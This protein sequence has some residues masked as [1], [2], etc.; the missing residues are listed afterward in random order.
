M[1][2]NYVMAVKTARMTATRDAMANGTLE[3][4]SAAGAALVVFGLNASGGTV[5]NDIWNLV[6]DSTT[7]AAVAGTNTVAT[8]AVLK[9]AGGTV[10]VSGLTV[11]VATGDPET[12]PDITLDAT[13]ITAGQNVTLSST[14]P[15][16][17]A[18]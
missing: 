6:F 18:A 9:N 13:A 1:A 4:Q 16:Q 14:A 11:G 3:I 17:H 10:L 8:Q 15:I 2:V 7:V 12:E 5:T